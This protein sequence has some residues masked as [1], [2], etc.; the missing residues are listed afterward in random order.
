MS[1]PVADILE[2]ISQE[3]GRAAQPQGHRATPRPL[4][5]APAPVPAPSPKRSPNPAPR[6]PLPRPG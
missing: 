1:R 5:P 2:D 4:V 3:L 6:R